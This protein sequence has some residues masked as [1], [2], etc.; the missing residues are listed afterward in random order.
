[1]ANMNNPPVSRK[2]REKC[3][4]N[5]RTKELKSNRKR[6]DELRSKK[7]SIVKKQIYMQYNERHNIY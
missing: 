2:K 5:N 7:E 3:N 1:M 6:M 4:S